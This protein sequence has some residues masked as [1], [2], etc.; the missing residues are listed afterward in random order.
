MPP[1]E[2][3]GF[4]FLYMSFDIAFVSYFV[5]CQPRVDGSSLKFLKA[6]LNLCQLRKPGKSQLFNAVDHHLVQT[7]TAKDDL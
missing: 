1:V 6:K 5:V 4:R 3:L 2:T 7:L